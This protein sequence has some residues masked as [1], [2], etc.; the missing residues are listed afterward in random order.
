MNQ[1]EQFSQE[2]EPTVEAPVHQLT[3]DELMTVGGG[4]G[5]KEMS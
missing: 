1:T 4:V 3:L 5:Q 2:I